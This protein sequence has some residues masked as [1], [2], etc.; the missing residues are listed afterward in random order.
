MIV[1]VSGIELTPGNHGRD[2]AGNGEANAECCCDECNYLLCCLT[3]Q[4]KE[5]CNLCEDA[6]CPR[7]ASN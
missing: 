6:E 2:C 3:L 5:N 7:R 4:W 1:D